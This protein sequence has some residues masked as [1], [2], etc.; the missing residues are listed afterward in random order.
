MITAE[1]YLRQ[2]PPLPPI[3]LVHG[4]EPWHQQQVRDALWRQA[5]AAGLNERVVLE[6]GADSDWDAIAQQTQAGSLFSAGQYFQLELPKGTPGKAGADFVRRWAQQP[7]AQ[8]ALAIFSGRLEARLLK[9]AWVQAIEQAG[10]V[11]QARAV[12]PMQLPKWCQQQAHA[13]GLTLTAEAAALLA[14]R[15]EGNLLA[16]AQALEVLQLRYGEGARIDVPEIRENVVDEAHYQLFALGDALLFGEVAQALHTLQ[17][18][19]QTGTDATLIV[20]LLAREVRLY[21]QLAVGRSPQALKIWRNQ[22][23]RYLAAAQRLPAGAWARVLAQLAAIDQMNKGLR[24]GDPWI[25]L[26]SIVNTICGEGT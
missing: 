11:I 20:W 3:V 19:R 26:D 12:P 21:Y 13:Y 1:A 25:A 16:A 24:A 9:S 10:L 5:Q 15:V 22:Q 18:L 17:R 6:A 4:D 8:A 7:P 14:E 23:S 2:P